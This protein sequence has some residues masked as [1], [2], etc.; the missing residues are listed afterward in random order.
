MRLGFVGLDMLFHKTF[1]SFIEVVNWCLSFSILTPCHHEI[2]LKLSGFKTANLLAWIWIVVFLF[3][4]F[5]RRSH[6]LISLLN[7]HAVFLV[8]SRNVRL[9]LLS[10]GCSPRFRVCTWSYEAHGTL[11]FLAGDF[12]RI[13]PALIFSPHLK[14]G[15]PAIFTNIS[16][17]GLMTSI[18]P[19]F[20]PTRVRSNTRN[21]LPFSCTKLLRQPSK[22]PENRWVIYNKYK[23][24]KTWLEPNQYRQL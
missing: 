20:N 18:R 8:Y 24:V 5:A 23:N 12:P 1:S 6:Y 9:M 21:P 3:S 2:I 19:T 4:Q 11:T 17:P 10:L 15:Q 22:G 13:F 7:Y 14:N 16:T